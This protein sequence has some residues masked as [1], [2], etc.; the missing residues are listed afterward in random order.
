ME[1][2]SRDYLYE[3]VEKQNSILD[4]NDSLELHLHG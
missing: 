4:E 1:I 2:L 3:Y